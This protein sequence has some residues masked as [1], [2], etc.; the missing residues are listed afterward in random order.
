MFTHKATDAWDALASGLMEAGFTITASWPVNT[1]S[2]GSLHIKEKS[3]ANSTIFLVCRPR[4]HRS[5]DE[6]AYWE[7][8]EPAV[9]VA[10]RKRIAEFQAA[11]VRGVDLYLSCFGPALEEFAKHWPLKRGT[12][13]LDVGKKSKATQDLDP[14]AVVPEDALD[15]ARREVKRWRMDKLL[16]LAKKS[17][18]DAV[19]EWFVLAWDAFEAPLFPYDEALRLARVVG[20]DLDSDIVGKIAEKKASDL[21]LLDSAARAANGSLGAATGAR[22]MIDAL[23][24]V[25]NRV[26]SRDL[27]AGRDLVEQLE[28]GT[29]PAFLTALKAVLE[30]LPVSSRFTKVEG[31][32]GAVAEAAN[33]FDALETLR[34]LMFAATVPEPEQLKIW[35]S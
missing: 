33:D 18:L 34:R 17:D 29:N 10:V 14:Y 20:V 6:I 7:D 28:L 11:G 12:P 23:H 8:V 35:E 25:A 24:H 13:R 32:K 22:S 31:E 5:D 3:A 2:E 27:Q 19:T 15:A 21:V 1:E 16:G 26:R 9:T 4:D 30:V